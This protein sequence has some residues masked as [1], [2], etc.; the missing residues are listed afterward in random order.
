M[1]E[2]EL[3]Y[4]ADLSTDWV[5]EFIVESNK[6]D[7]QPGADEPGSLIYD[8]HREAVMYAIRMAAESRYALPHSVHKLLLGDHPLA[9]KLRRRE[10]KIG[11]NYILEPM[12]VSHYIW[13]WNRSVH[14]V[15]N[16]LRLKGITAEHRILAVWNLHC[17]FEN[18]HP[19]ELYNGKAGRVL[20]L[21]HALLVDVEPWIIS[22]EESREDYFDLI[23]NHPSADWGLAAC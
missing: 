20:L 21:N 4:Q 3:L 17:E 12:Y 1:E 5:H 13:T 6:I 18:I 14:R 7:P 19:Y 23:R 8:G 9:G 16:N 22:C 15:I 10:L 11:L 2:S